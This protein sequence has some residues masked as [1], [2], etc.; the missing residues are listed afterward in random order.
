MPCCCSERSYNFYARHLQPTPK[1]YRAY[2]I[3]R[4]RLA[5]FHQLD[6]AFHPNFYCTILPFPNPFPCLRCNT[7]SVCL[8]GRHTPT[9]L[10]WEAAGPPIGRIAWHHP[11]SLRQPADEVGSTDDPPNISARLH[12]SFLPKSIFNKGRTK[13]SSYYYFLFVPKPSR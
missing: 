6:G 2:H 7:L 13:L 9:V 8:P 5:P 10:R 4:M 12:R 11:S 1:H 3:G